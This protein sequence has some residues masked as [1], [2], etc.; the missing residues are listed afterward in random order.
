M[1]IYDGFLCKIICDKKAMNIV[2][3]ANDKMNCVV[4]CQ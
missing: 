4:E 2:F 3:V 1:L